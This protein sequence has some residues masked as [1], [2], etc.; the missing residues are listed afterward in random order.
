MARK[1]HPEC[2]KCDHRWTVDM[3]YTEEYGN[4]KLHGCRRP[5][6]HKFSGKSVF[7]CVD[8]SGPP[9]DPKFNILF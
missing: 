4:Y 8:Y 1:E 9:K 5:T 6:K 2:W 7:G 3:D